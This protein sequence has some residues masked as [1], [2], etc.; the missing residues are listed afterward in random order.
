MNSIHVLS[1]ILGHNR[2]RTVRDYFE[3][4]RDIILI[5]KYIYVL[6]TCA[7]NCIGS[8]NRHFLDF[9][10]SSK[11]TVCG[12][13]EYQNINKPSVVWCL[14]CDEGLCEECKVH[15]A[16]SKATRDHSV[17]LRSDYQNL[18]SNILENTQ[19]CPKHDE[20]YVI[21]CRKHDI[22]CCRRCVVET[23][24][25]CRDLNAIEDVI[26]NVKSSNAFL[27]M[28]KVL[29]ELSENLQRISEKI[30]KK[31]LQENLTKELY[32][33]E[34]KENKSITNIISSI[35]E[36][37][38]KV[39]ESQTIL[40]KVKQHASDLQ[41][42]LA[43]KHIQRDVTINEQFLES[44]IKQE[45]INNASISWKNE[46]AVEILSNQIKKI[47][48]II[49]DTRPGDTILTSSKNQQAQKV[50]PTTPVPSIDDVKLTLRR[51]VKTFGSDIISCCFFPDGRMV[52]SC[53]G[54]DKI[55]VLKTNGSLDFTLKPGSKTSH[56]DFI[57][58]SQQLVVTSGFNYKYIKIINVIN[59]KTEK[60]VVV[61]T[62]IYGIV[63]KDEK[64]FYN[65]G[66]SW[67]TCCNDDSVTCCDLQGAVKWKVE[68]YTNLKGARGITVDNYG[69]VYV[70]GYESNNVV[71]ISTDGSK[72][73]VLLS[74]KDGLKKPQSLCFNRKNNNLLIAN[75]ENDAFIYDI[76]K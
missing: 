30:D 21:F 72:H 2:Q 4:N 7:N 5:R 22:P 68:L 15:H 60:T 27:E 31:T 9:S 12:V 57:E 69:R 70:S 18:P 24:N 61:G 55:H 56:I 41:T 62:Q 1:E 13:C 66:K 16:A 32:D 29:K 39:T 59:R 36:K 58:K 11:C 26:K 73:R 46:N 33:V 19:T 25:D 67:I 51:T 65:G 34:E 75:Q 10:M 63:H 76:L 6:V 17:V 23:H 37:E 8:G 45:K 71:V 38:R 20:K 3:F 49:L 74:G 48:T 28:E 44:L 47:G 42:F 43:M 52:F 50:L 35:E 53:Y 14:E 64:L 54:N 40:D